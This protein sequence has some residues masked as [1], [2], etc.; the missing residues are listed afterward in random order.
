MP[1]LLHTKRTQLAYHNPLEVYLKLRDEMGRDQVFILESLF[2]PARDTSA[3][4]IGCGSFAGLFVVDDQVTFHGDTTVVQAFMEVSLS[5]GHVRAGER[6]VKLSKPF[7]LWDLLNSLS[8]LLQLKA[9]VSDQK[10]GPG[11]FGYFGYD[12][13]WQ[14][15]KLPSR[16]PSK[17]SIPSVSLLLYSHLISVDS[18]SGEVELLT[19]SPHADRLDTEHARISSCLNSAAPQPAPEVDD[20]VAQGNFGRSMPTIV[21][22]DYLPKVKTA[23][24]HIAKG[25]I[26]QIQVGHEIMVSSSIDPFS[27][28]LRLRKS[29]PSPYMFFA[30]FDQA[31]VVGASPEL[32]VSV[33]AGQIVMRPIAGTIR[34]GRDPAEDA[35]LVAQLKNDTKEL[36]EHI[37]LVDLCRN[38]IGRICEPGSLNV[39]ELLVVED[40]SHVHH[41]VSNVVAQLKPEYRSFDVIRATFPAGTMTGAPKIRAMEIIEDLEVTRRDVYAG[42]IGLIDL[43]GKIKMALCIRMCNWDRNGRYSIRASAGIV[44]DSTPENEWNESILKMSAPYLAITGRAL[45]Q[46]KFLTGD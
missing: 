24:E 44:A 16:I 35:A 12:A 27:V 41:L 2:G 14:I 29:N 13:T 15:E 36:A 37:M 40:Y 5:L 8:D 18:R 6:S 21:K 11:F 25:D 7:A 45:G 23:L 20:T 4:F 38:D 19:I 10:F 1:I 22:A 32:F 26:Y 34:R 31:V 30:P 39:D 46:E 28:Y 17:E 33:D 42:A 9:P 3:S 43:A